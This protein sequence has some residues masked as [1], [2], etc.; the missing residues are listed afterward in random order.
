VRGLGSA[1]GV[2]AILA[3]GAYA[4]L[5]A[6]TARDAA[7]L[8]GPAAQRPGEPAGSRCPA[9]DRPLRRDRVEL[10]REELESALARGNVV[11]ESPEPAELTGL[12]EA[13][14]GPFDSELAAAGQMVVLGR[15]EGPH[16]T[17]LAFGRRLRVASPADPRLRDFAEA[18]LGN[19]AGRRCD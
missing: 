16:V 6:V 13:V 5:Q 2:L 10:G 1:L 8:A 19:R 14:S 12:Q 18:W 3:L 4:L 11:L 15:G 17:A 7:D 9:V